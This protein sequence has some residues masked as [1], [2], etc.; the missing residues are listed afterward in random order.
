MALPLEGIRVL[1]LTLWLLGPL[2]TAMLADM[3]ADVVKIEAPTRQDPARRPGVTGQLTGEPSPFFETLNRHKRSLLLDLKTPRGREVLYRLVRKADVLVQNYRP[4]VAER[5][6]VDYQTLAAINPRLIY[7]YGTG[8]GR[9]GPDAGLP[10]LDLCLQARGGIMGVTGDADGPP[11][12]TFYAAVDQLASH[13]L[14][15]GILAALF[16]RERTG[17]GQEVHVSLLGAALDAQA[18]YIATALRTGVPFSRP[19]HFTSSPLWNRYRGSDGR[20]FILAMIYIGRFWPLLCQAIGR[21][22]L[23]DKFDAQTFQEDPARTEA[24]VRTLDEVFAQRPA[25]EWVKILSEAGLRVAPVQDYLELAQ[26]PQVVANEMLVEMDHP[27][28]GRMKMVRG[29]IDL[30][31]TPPR[32]P[33]PAPAPGQHTRQVLLDYGFTPQ[34]VEALLEEGVVAEG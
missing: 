7:A 14:A 11:A 21:P 5:L 27:R 29:P 18:P 16:H 22:D 28:G 10:A 4:G 23:I 9:R 30:S 19:S 12:Q 26:D 33:S 13:H 1:D 25:A 32:R 6:G 34:E 31:E 15:Y 2:A 3:G 24:M 17:Q 20:Y 8:Y